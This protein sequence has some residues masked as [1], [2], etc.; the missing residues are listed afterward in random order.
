MGK[1]KRILNVGFCVVLSFMLLAGC[2]DGQEVE[3]SEATQESMQVK[4]ESQTT[5]KDSAQ[6]KNDSQTPKAQKT[7]IVVRGQE[8][9]E[10]IK[11][12]VALF[13]EQSEA[14]V[15]QLDTRTNGVN[16]FQKE[17]YEE[18]INGLG[19]DIFTVDSL[20]DTYSL[21]NT[22]IVAD[23]KLYL[24]VSGIREED[25]FSFA[26][27][28]WREEDKIYGVNVYVQPEG[29]WMDA[30]FLGEEPY[31]VESMLTN[32]QKTPKSVFR[33][34]SSWEKDLAYC[35]S[36]SDNLWGMIDEQ[37]GTC[38][39]QTELLKQLIETFY[40]HS[41]YG[42]N[43]V[44]IVAG[45]L[46][47]T[48]WY[49]FVSEEELKKEGKVRIGYFSDD[50]LCTFSSLDNM[51]LI[52]AN[53]PNVEGAW[54]F[55]EFMLGEQAQSLMKYDRYPVSREVF[56]KLM[57]H[58]MEEGAVM[59]GE[60]TVLKAGNQRYYEENGAEAY[61]ARFDLTEEK[62]AEIRSIVENAKATS[63]KTASIIKIIAE[64]Y[65]L[66]RWEDTSV[67]EFASLV[68]AKVKRYLDEVK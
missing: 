51:F 3:Q 8:F 1:R 61:R 11:E 49:K 14:Y 7:K 6:G 52:N 27:D 18:L 12:C 50:G 28:G 41:F 68:E 10:L 36:G 64:E 43:D 2:G 35:L 46:M 19:A 32:M 5:S 57:T 39:L 24:E 9:D 53:S 21:V 44:P 17:T 30:D 20:S 23:L 16:E 31:T 13:N 45:A 65:R 62:I 40:N 4:E 26:I 60:D 56:E 48:Y 42:R 67:E 66:Y 25:Y 47:D 59:D 37:T 22:G 34:Y 55:L 63:L 38:N 33:Q 15:V 58:E 54:E 29:C